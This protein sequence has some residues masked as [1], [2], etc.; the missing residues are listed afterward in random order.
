ML[1]ILLAGAIASITFGSGSFAAD[2]VPTK[3]APYA[4]PATTWTGWYIGANAGGVWGT[5]NPNFLIDDRL[6]YYTFGAGNGANVARVIGVSNTGVD[7]SG[8]TAGGQLGYNLQLGY[9]VYGIEADLNYFHP[10]GSDTRNSTLPPAGGTCTVGG[11]CSPFTVS[12]STS[13]DWLATLRGRIGMTWNNWLFYA[14]GG[15]AVAKLNFAASYADASAPLAVTSGSLR[16]N[17]SGSDTRLGL[18]IGAG[19]EYAL[20]ENWSLRAEYL[21]VRIDGPDLNTRAVPT[22]GSTGN[23]NAVTVFC[24]DFGYSPVFQEHV[25]RGAINY[26][27]H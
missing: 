13:A 11:A 2:L 7:N 21:Y 10:T 18:A 15:L 17:V 8:F 1:R 5:A 26:R 22:V 23:C 19:G 20:T 12:Y 16:S 3:A 9:W 24:S 27:F 25:A 4:A 6:L 14:T